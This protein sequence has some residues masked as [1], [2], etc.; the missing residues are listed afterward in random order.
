V[1]RQP[2]GRPQKSAA[3]ASIVEQPGVSTRAKVYQW[4]SR[5]GLA[6]CA[7]I[8]CALL[9]SF[10][11]RHTT[12]SAIAAAYGGA[13]GESIGYSS[14]IVGRDFLNEI[15]NTHAEHRSFGI[16][17]VGAVVTGLVA[18]FG[19][20]GLLDTFVIRPFTMG[21]G[22]RLIGPGLGLIAGKVAAD[23]LFYIPVIF[24]YER[25]KRWRRRGAGG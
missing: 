17:G 9:G 14:V 15:R 5:Y 23:I 18:E 4:V 8:T 19:P 25:K 10:I 24:M 13:W 11:V 2:A 7:G 1:N 16:G 12:H 6:E 3:L 20:S 21:V 22:E